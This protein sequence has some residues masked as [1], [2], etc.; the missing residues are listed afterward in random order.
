M[1]A[2]GWHRL[3]DAVLATLRPGVIAR[4]FSALRRL[5]W[6]A[7][8]RAMRGYLALAHPGVACAP[9]V[10]FGRGVRVRAFAGGRA[11]IGAGATLD[12][13]AHVVVEGGHLVIGAGVLVGRGALVV[14][15][16]AISIGAGSLIGEYVTVRDQDHRHAGSGPLDA[17]GLI[18]A[19]VRIG[20]QVWLGAK[21]TVTRG[22]DIA[23][24]AV[25]GANAVVTR[26]L[27]GRGVYGG[28]PA[29]RLGAGVQP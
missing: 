28:I 24:N 23:A 19:P 25:V 13:F 21:V 10:R 15:C 18:T 2:P 8:S 7:R 22:V 29:R 16:E 27:A 1:V 14:C 6:W 12:D 20:E 4:A 11:E 3:T 26:S 17:Q 5:R 9:G